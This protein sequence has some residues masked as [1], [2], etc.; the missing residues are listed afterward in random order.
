MACTGALEIFHIRRL[1]PSGQ[2]LLLGVS[3]ATTSSRY[4]HCLRGQSA[5]SPQEPLAESC[6]HGATKSPTV[7]PGGHLVLG[8]GGPVVAT[9]N[10][11]SG[12]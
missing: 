9:N 2:F 1:R 8:S 12:A 3:F 11:G 7:R 10:I 5:Q 4:Q 6:D